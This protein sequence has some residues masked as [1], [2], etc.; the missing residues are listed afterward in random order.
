MGLGDVP[1]C[2]AMAILVIIITSPRLLSSRGD[3]LL[4]YV[5]FSL[6]LLLFFHTFCPLDFSEMP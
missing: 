5:S 4:F 1:Y 6:F 3:V 2:F